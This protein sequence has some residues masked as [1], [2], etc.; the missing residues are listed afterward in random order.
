M[1]KLKICISTDSRGV[2]A[3]PNTTWCNILSEQNIYDIVFSRAN[4]RFFSTLWDHV[5]DIEQTNKEFDLGIIQLGYGD[6]ILAWEMPVWRTIDLQD[7]K[8]E[9]SLIK[10]PEFYTN[11]YLSELPLRKRKGF[12]RIKN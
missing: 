10:I 11:G 9:K 5:V 4:N 7:E 2:V 1:D 3:G 6:Y 12:P 8:W